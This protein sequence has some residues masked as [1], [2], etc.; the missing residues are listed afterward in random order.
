MLR[1]VSLL[2]VIQVCSS[3]VSFSISIVFIGTLG[4]NTYGE[5]ALGQAVSSYFLTI[6]NGFDRSLVRELS[7]I[8]DIFQKER[9]QRSVVHRCIFLIILLIP[10]IALT[11][12]GTVSTL[13]M[14]V[15]FAESLKSVIPYPIADSRNLLGRLMLIT[16]ADRAAQLLVLLLLVPLIGEAGFCLYY[17]AASLMHVAFT[18]TQ[19]DLQLFK[20][21]ICFSKFK[22]AEFLLSV[23][24]ALKDSTSA[25]LSLSYGNWPKIFFGIIGDFGS[26]AKFAVSWQVASF[27]CTPL[28]LTCRK[29]TASFVR[30]LTSTKSKPTDESRDLMA[31]LRKPVIMLLAACLV[32]YILSLVIGNGGE[33]I[34]M[35][36]EL[37]SK[38]SKILLAAPYLTAVTSYCGFGQIANMIEEMCFYSLPAREVSLI[39]AIYSSVSLAL[40]PYTYYLGG[41]NAIAVTILACHLMASLNLTYARKRKNRY[42]Q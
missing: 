14:T 20:G 8:K 9:I 30:Q 28:A 31:R 23:Q 38:A 19:L 24:R 37:H 21:E 11:R 40:V 1:E 2:T 39:A 35:L 7:R 4:L 12:T 36:S 6:G 18:L 34:R 3:L 22:P 26:L 42:I 27:V 17:V 41:I 25:F 10:S 13:V 5:F 32:A 33:T 16:L 29:E 15:A